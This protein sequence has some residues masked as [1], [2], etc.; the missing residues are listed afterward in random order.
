MTTTEKEKQ[1]RI[2]RLQG[3]ID[4]ITDRYQSDDK[5]AIEVLEALRDRIE[6]I[7]SG[8]C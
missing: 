6:L 2:S 4:Y 5:T 8:G 1:D 3:Q 7:E